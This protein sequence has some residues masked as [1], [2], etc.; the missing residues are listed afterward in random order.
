MKNKTRWKE[1]ILSSFDCYFTRVAPLEY[2]ERS[3][4]Y[5]IRSHEEKLPFI[6]LDDQ[7]EIII[8]VTGND[9]GD[10]SQSNDRLK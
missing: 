3:E 1:N 7:I 10:F 4:L 8:L 2:R 5:Q 6:R 9:G